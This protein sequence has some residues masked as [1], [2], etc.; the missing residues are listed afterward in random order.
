M[1]Y[2]SKKVPTDGYMAVRS[3]VEVVLQ[4]SEMNWGEEEIH[5]A[6]LEAL[7]N[8]ATHFVPQHFSGQNHHRARHSIVNRLRRTDFRN[9]LDNGYGL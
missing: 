6:T 3:G 9:R 2:Q 1:R 4:K 8:Y 7:H 5:Q